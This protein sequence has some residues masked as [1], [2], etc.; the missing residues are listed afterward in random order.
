[1]LQVEQRHAD[2]ERAPVRRAVL[3]LASVRRRRAQLALRQLLQLTHRVAPRLPR[4]RPLAP[5]RVARR[6]LAPCLQRQLPAAK[7][8]VAYRHAKG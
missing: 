3:R 6:R 5:A 7:R 8:G 1:M 4:R 2:R